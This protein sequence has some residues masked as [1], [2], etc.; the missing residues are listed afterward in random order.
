MEAQSI[1]ERLEVRRR[2]RRRRARG[3]EERGDGGRASVGVRRGIAAGARGEPIGRARLARRRR[4]EVERWEL[5]EGGGDGED[6]GEAADTNGEVEVRRV[7]GGGGER[8]ALRPRL[9]VGRRLD[10][11]RRRDRQPRERAHHRDLK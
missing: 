4:G 8:D 3:V 5:G 1:G 11:A 7:G 6:G 10:R 2:H 9:A